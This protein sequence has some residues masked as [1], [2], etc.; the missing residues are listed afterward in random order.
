M[1]P[2]RLPR[3]RPRWRVW[4]FTPYERAVV[5]AL[6][7]VVASASEARLAAN[8]RADLAILRRRAR[9]RGRA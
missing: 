5:R 1:R 2:R 6:A 7:R 4:A 3:P 9:A 8:A